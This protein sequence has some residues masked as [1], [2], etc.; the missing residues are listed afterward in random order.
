MMQEALYGRMTL[1]RCLKREFGFLG[2]HVN[3]LDKMDSLCSG[4]NSCHL[5]RPS[6]VDFSVKGSEG[7]CVEGLELYLETRH[8]CVTG[9]FLLT[10]FEAILQV[11]YID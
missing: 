2:C 3:V 6:K 10:P 8:T 1:G 5:Q 7:E 11:E 4:K 9:Q